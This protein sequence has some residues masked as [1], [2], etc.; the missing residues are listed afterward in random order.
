M[1]EED[2]G[3]EGEGRRRRV[4]CE[5]GWLCRKGRLMQLGS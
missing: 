5:R 4:T 2:E 3:K 1:K